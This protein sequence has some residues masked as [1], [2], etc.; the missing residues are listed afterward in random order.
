MNTI[1]YQKIL[2]ICPFK[3]VLLKH[4]PYLSIKLL[5]IKSLLVM[6]TR[7]TISIREEDNQV[8]TIYCHWDGYIDGVGQ[9]LKDNYSDADK[10]RELINLGDISSLRAKVKPM[11]GYEDVHTFDSP[12]SDVTIAYGRDRGESNIEPREYNIFPYEKQEYS[13]MFDVKTNTWLVREDY[14]D[15]SNTFREY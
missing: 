5:I 9:E 4:Y 2:K 3:F 7:S 8:K 12:L 10:V 14:N 13:Y 11:E 1:I 15:S 6:A